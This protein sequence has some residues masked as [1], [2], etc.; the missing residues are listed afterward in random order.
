MSSPTV[1]TIVK[2]IETLPQAAQERVAEHLR[3]YIADL[4]DESRWDAAFATTQSK[5]VDAA[6]RARQDIAKGKARPMN[7]DEL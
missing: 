5:L 3:E 2:M 4:D 6:Q 1:A 7:H